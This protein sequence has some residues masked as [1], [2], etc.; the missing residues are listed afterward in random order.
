MQRSRKAEFTANKA[1]MKLAAGRGNIYLF[2]V[3]L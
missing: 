2:P 1:A 3:C